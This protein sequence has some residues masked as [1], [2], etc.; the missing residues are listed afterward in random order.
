MFGPEGLDEPNPHKPDDFN[1]TFRGNIDDCFRV[2]LKFSRKQMK[3]Y[4]SFYSSDVIIASPLGLKMIIGE[5]GDKKREFDFLS[6][7]EVIILNH[8]DTFLM[9]N[10]DHVR[11]YSF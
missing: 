8:T 1:Q 9:Q 4:S 2:G 3:I 7:I 11:V 6:S 10:W 5:E